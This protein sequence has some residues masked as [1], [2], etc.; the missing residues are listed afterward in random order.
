MVVKRSTSTRHHGGILTIFVSRSVLIAILLW[1][2]AATAG[3]V[4]RT[5]HAGS[6]QEIFE[7]SK[8]AREGASGA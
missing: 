5:V 1:G 3:E 4:Y 7:C 6:S 2:G 8:G